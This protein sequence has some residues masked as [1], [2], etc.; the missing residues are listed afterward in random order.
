MRGSRDAIGT[1]A[2]Y[3]QRMVI[4]GW[5]AEAREIQDAARGD[6]EV[7]ARVQAL[8]RY[9]TDAFCKVLWPGSVRALRLEAQPWDTIDDLAPVDRPVECPRTWG[10]VARLVHAIEKRFDDEG[11]AD[12]RAL[13]P[14]PRCPE[15]VLDQ[16]VGEISKVDG[17]PSRAE[18]ERWARYLRWV[19]EATERPWTWGQTFGQLRRWAAEDRRL[20]VD[21]LREEYAPPRGSTW[22]S[23]LGHDPERKRRRDEFRRIMRHYPRPEDNPPDIARQDWLRRALV[24]WS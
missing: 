11:W 17:L 23:L 7:F 24:F 20:A 22:A 4:L 19:R 2:S 21:E 3:G 9:I 10:E 8:V 15:A 13:R 18:L 16:V 5:V 14:E 1:L 6:P 12:D